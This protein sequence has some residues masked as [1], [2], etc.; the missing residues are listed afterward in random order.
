MGSQN[1]NVKHGLKSNNLDHKVDMQRHLIKQV[2]ESAG[3]GTNE[4]QSS[5][6]VFG[7]RMNPT[8]AA[9]AQNNSMKGY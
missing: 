6:A 5:G 8:I 2:R 7:V 9:T 3:S 4:G 1:S